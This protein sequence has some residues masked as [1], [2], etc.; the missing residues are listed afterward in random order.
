MK[1]R[2]YHSDNGIFWDI[3]RNA[4]VFW[5]FSFEKCVEDMPAMSKWEAMDARQ[6]FGILWTHRDFF[7]LIIIL[8]IKNK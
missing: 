3:F 6:I 7:Y 5:S 8:I 4:G 2:D 1:G